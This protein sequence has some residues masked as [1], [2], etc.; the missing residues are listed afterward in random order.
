MLEYGGGSIAEVFK[1]L[2][3]KPQMF[4][5][6]VEGNKWRHNGA[7]SNGLTI[8]EVWERVEKK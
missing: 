7:L 1:D 3:G 4:E 6:K 8:E 2:K 5:C